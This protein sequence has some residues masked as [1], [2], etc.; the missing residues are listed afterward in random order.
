MCEFGKL[1]FMQDIRLDLEKAKPENQ[2]P[3]PIFQLARLA[4]LCQLKYYAW[5]QG[6]A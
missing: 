2:N 3:N 6:L 1:E 5:D 4:Y